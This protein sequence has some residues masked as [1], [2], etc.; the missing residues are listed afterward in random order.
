MSPGPAYGAAQWENN[1]QGNIL[2]GRAIYVGPLHPTLLPK[3]SLLCGIEISQCVYK[4]KV[5]R[6]LTGAIRSVSKRLVV[7]CIATPVLRLQ[8]VFP[9]TMRPKQDR[10]LHLGLCQGQATRLL[11]RRPAQRPA[12]NWGR[13][14]AAPDALKTR[15]FKQTFIE[16]NILPTR[17]DTK[18]KR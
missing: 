2:L 18:R 11:A 16:R 13:H 5:Q 1:L 14:T 9:H 8:R 7:Y 3:L 10:K 17:N 4:G 12:T 6:V 15:H